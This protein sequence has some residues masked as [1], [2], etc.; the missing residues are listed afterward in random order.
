MLFFFQTILAFVFKRPKVTPGSFQAFHSF[1]ELKFI[2]WT[3]T[4][5]L[6]RTLHP[7]TPFSYVHLRLVSI[8]ICCKLNAMKKR[9]CTFHNFWP[10]SKLVY[11]IE[12]SQTISIGGNFNGALY[13]VTPN[14]LMWTKARQQQVKCCEYLQKQKEKCGKRILSWVNKQTITAV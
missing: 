8:S 6:S 10:H 9:Y 12:K 13:L 14:I 7:S 2:L 1:I 4:T 11:C 5:H 3:K